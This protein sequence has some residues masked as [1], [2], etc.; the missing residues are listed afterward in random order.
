MGSYGLPGLMEA[1]DPDLKV[2]PV[3]VFQLVSRQ[4]MKDQ[5]YNFWKGQDMSVKQESTFFVIQII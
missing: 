3:P 2:S 1:S 5:L 4:P